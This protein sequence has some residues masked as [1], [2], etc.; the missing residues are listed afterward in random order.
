MPS[1]AR[2]ADG[3]G[4]RSDPVTATT[5]A[6]PKE[7]DP[8]SSARQADTSP[9]TL[10]SATVAANGESIDLVLNEVYDLPDTEVAAI[11][12]LTTLLTHFRVTADGVN[13]PLSFTD[14]IDQNHRDPRG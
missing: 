3:L 14:R 13:V 6:A 8:P 10:V 7:D 1:G 12:Y 2:N 4:P 5:S 9:P 11:T